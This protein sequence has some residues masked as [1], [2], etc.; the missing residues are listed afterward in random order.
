MKQKNILETITEQEAEIFVD[1]EMARFKRIGDDEKALLIFK[2]T[3]NI[4]FKA[5]DTSLYEQI[6]GIKR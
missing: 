1:C 4:Y 3:G 5:E 2:R 6:G